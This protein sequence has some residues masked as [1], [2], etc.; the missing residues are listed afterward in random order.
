MTGFGPQGGVRL[1]R[2][3]HPPDLRRSVPVVVGRWVRVTE[4]KEL[5]ERGMG[6]R[7]VEGVEGWNPTRF[8]LPDPPTHTHPS[9]TPGA[10]P[11]Q[12]RQSTELDRIWREPDTQK[13]G[14]GVRG[15]PFF[16]KKRSSR[17]CRTRSTYHLRVFHK[18]RSQLITE[19][20]RTP[21]VRPAR[22]PLDGQNPLVVGS[23]G[24]IDP[25]LRLP[26]R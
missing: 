12:V 20:I 16:F 18:R 14:S 25:T 5:R 2:E 3:T 7:V 23:I 21:G 15:V 11:D 4:E 19:R 10:L 26:S 9:V 8:T 6:S 24:S 13:G 17:V 22:G 1:L